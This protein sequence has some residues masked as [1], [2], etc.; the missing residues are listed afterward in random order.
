MTSFHLYLLPPSGPVPQSSMLCNV[1]SKPCSRQKRFSLI[2]AEN[3]N[4]L[5]AVPVLSG[6][7]A[8]SFGLKLDI[9][10]ALSPS[11][12]HFSPNFATFTCWRGYCYF[13]S[14]ADRSAVYW[15]TFMKLKIA[16]LF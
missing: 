15:A 13:D 1:V 8:S 9:R 12:G 2:Y 4:F 7:L 16:G 14:T 11:V 10:T 6:R 5:N 3:R